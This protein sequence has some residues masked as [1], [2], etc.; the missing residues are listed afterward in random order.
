VIADQRL[1]MRRVAAVVIPCRD[2]GSLALAFGDQHGVHRGKEYFKELQLA[3]QLVDQQ[4][5]Y[6]LLA[7]YLIMSHAATRCIKA[8]NVWRNFS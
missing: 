5:Y 3:L 7:N 8:K 1:A 2:H 6:V 4:V